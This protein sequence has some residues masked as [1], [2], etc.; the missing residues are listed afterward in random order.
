MSDITRPTTPTHRSAH[1]VARLRRR[2][3]LLLVAASVMLAACDTSPPQ[4][5]STR[6]INGMAVAGIDHRA[7]DQAVLDFLDQRG[8][9]RTTLPTTHAGQAQKGTP[10]LEGGATVAVT[11][12]SRLVLSRSYGWADEAAGTPMLPTHRS[13]I[14][15]VSKFITALA[16]FQLAETGQLDLD[17]P[18][19]GDPGAVSMSGSWPSADTSTWPNATSVLASPWMY[20]TAMRDGS[21]ELAAPG[22]ASSMMDTNRA[23]ASQIT[24][25]HLLTHTSGFLRSGTNAHL[26]AYFGQTMKD[27][28]MAH[29]GVLRGAIREEV[30]EVMV[31]VPPL[32]FAP[33]S[34]R[35][36]SNHG[37]GLLGHIVQ[38][39]S[40]G[41][42]YHGYYDHVKANILDPLGLDSVVGNNWDLDSGLDAWPHGDELDPNKRAQFL[43]TGSWSATA[44]D[45]S[46]IACAIDGSSNHL[47]LLTPERVDEL[48]SVPFPEARASQPHGWDRVR[49]GT[50]FYKGGLTGGGS[51]FLLKVL[52]GHFGAAPQDEINVAIAFNSTLPDQVVDLR[53][54]LARHIAS[55]VADAEI[56]GDDDL[57]APEHRCAIEGPTI[58]ILAPGNGQEFKLDEEVMFEAEARD[59]TG[60]ALPIW[61]S[62]PVRG[63]DEPPT[64]PG[65]DGIH[66]A[67]HSGF[68]EGTHTIEV[69]TVDS[70]GNEAKA[71]VTI[72]VIYDRPTAEILHP[73]HGDTLIAGEPMELAG[74]SSSSVF[75]LSDDQVRWRVRRNGVL[76]HQGSGHVRS[77]PATMMSPGTYEISFIVDDG[78]SEATAEAVVVVEP[79]PLTDPTAT[80]HTPTGVGQEVSG[81]EIGFSGSGVDSEGS[82]ISGTRFRWTA[83]FAGETKVLCDGT[84][85]P[86]SSASQGGGGG[87]LLAVTDCSSFTATLQGV[88]IAS[89]T[90]FTIR[91]QVWDVE[92]NTHT[93]VRPIQVYL[94]PVG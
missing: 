27:Y 73:A 1:A 47:R 28:R 14:G 22:V 59:A 12:G 8:D 82:S 51:A 60:A 17:M 85:T 44:Q 31:R 49:G 65:A 4:P 90:T 3:A 57:F 2:V 43:A 88:H 70:G 33:G 23:W 67:F 53:L 64:Q 94:P 19:Y 80:I 42:V 69:T 66:A 62:A 58:T 26:E 55:I 18:L 86:S 81:S 48:H 46:R 61:W 87:G 75:A 45:L 21:L 37:F 77:V 34:Q 93:A 78:K 32:R 91:L 63:A 54:D 89:T 84:H 10:R 83:T 24:P 71:Q 38:E 9:Y 56:G 35:S 50:E 11:R 76:V 74:Q 39:A 72:E 7:I 6:P 40:G 5:S 68:G 25:R 20:W 52:P 16:V 92:G 15:S 29:M 41:R 79:K 30:D 13:R 36:Y